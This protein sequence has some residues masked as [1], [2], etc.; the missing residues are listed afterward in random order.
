VYHACLHFFFEN[1]ARALLFIKEGTRK[2][3]L[4][5]K[6]LNPDKPGENIKS[7]RAHNRGQRPQPRITKQEQ[8]QPEVEHQGR[9]ERS[10]WLWVGSILTG[11]PESPPP[12]RPL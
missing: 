2:Y 11:D 8:K 12:S 4:R 7:N 3:N 1:K 9:I 5:Y 6:T 10:K